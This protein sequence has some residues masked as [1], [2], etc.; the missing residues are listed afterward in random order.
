M[1]EDPYQPPNSCRHPAPF[2][3]SYKNSLE[4]LVDLT[5][6]SRH[7]LNMAIRG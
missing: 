1:T 3:R 6:G 7:L 2:A 5:L 4:W